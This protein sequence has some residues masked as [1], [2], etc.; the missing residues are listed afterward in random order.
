[1]P[2]ITWREK[3]YF[4]KKRYFPSFSINIFYT[5]SKAF[6]LRIKICFINIF[7]CPLVVFPNLSM[8]CGCL[9]QHHYQMIGLWFSAQGAIRPWHTHSKR[10]NVFFIDYL[11]ASMEMGRPLVFLQRKHCKRRNV[12]FIISFTAFRQH[13]TKLSTKINNTLTGET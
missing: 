12:A 6:L 9:S 3:V 8:S 10:E 5:E 1:M 11:H 2:S 13:E 7:L 4:K